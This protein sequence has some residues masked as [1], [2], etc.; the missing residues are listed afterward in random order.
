M[1]TD[2]V[3]KAVKLIEDLI[4]DWTLHGCRK[5]KLE[6]AKKAVKQLRLLGVTSFVHGGIKRLSAGDMQTYFWECEYSDGEVVRF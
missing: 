6:K 3:W 1:D 4:K 2:E 5:S